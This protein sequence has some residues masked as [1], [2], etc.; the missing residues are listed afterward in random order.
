[1]DGVAYEALVKDVNT[2]KLTYA[3]L[4]ISSSGSAYVDSEKSSVA[5]SLEKVVPENGDPYLMVN[6]FD[7]AENVQKSDLS[8]RQDDYDV[9]LR[10]RNGGLVEMSY[11]SLKDIQ[12]SGAAP[13]PAGEINY[14]WM[15][16]KDA[17]GNYVK[18]G[19]GSMFGYYLYGN[20][21]RYVD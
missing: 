6:G 15:W 19:V 18:P 13:A 16:Q 9:L 14:N 17:E 4:D 11:A 12:L 2:G 1:M 21:M 3:S 8:T 20:E 7:T 10:H 5:R